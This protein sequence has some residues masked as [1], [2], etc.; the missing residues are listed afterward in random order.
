VVF[1]AQRDEMFRALKGAGATC[2]ADV[3]AVGGAPTLATALVATGFGYAAERRAVQAEWVAHVL[4]RVRDIRRAG[5]AAL[6]LCWVAAG[7]VDAYYEQGTH[8]WDY[9]AG[10]LVASE[11]GAWVGGFDGGPP[12][13]DGLVAAAPQ[14]ADPLRKLLA[15]ARQPQP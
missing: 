3:L 8:I 5:S 4:P 9:A 10:A 14:L 13:T 2:N 11:A 12:S 1:D 15:D 6:D 7:R